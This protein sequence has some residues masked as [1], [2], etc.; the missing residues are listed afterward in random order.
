VTSSRRDICDGRHPRN[1]GSFCFGNDRLGVSSIGGVVVCSGGVRG[2]VLR[3]GCR[4]GPGARSHYWLVWACVAAGRV[5]V[6]SSRQAQGRAMVA[7]HRSRDELV[8]G[9]VRIEELEM[10]G[11][12]QDEIDAYFAPDFVFH[13]TDGS[14]RALLPR[15]QR[16]GRGAAHREVEAARAPARPPRQPILP[17]AVRRRPGPRQTRRRASARRPRW[18]T[19]PTST[20][21]TPTGS[22]ARPPRTPRVR[23]IGISYG[24]QGHRAAVHC[25]RI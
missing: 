8:A 14:T 25:G 11:E 7:G 18:R 4:A 16:Q 19:R 15:Q 3:I 21:R 10:T 5:L 1:L 9:L 22:C 13:D 20:W 24:A 23:E 17:S 2:H 12:R 6:A